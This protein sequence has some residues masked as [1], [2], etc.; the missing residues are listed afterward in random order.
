MKNLIVD[1]P[2]P[3]RLSGRNLAIS[4]VIYNLL[5]EREELFSFAVYGDWG[6][7]KT[8]V[9]K[10]VYNRLKTTIEKN[11]TL[12]N[13]YSI[14][15]WFEAW[16]FQNEKFIFPAMLRTIGSEIAINAKSAEAITLCKRLMKNSMAV[17]KA[18]ISSVK[19]SA[20]YN[21]PDTG[22]GGGLE[23]SGNDFLERF[24]SEMEKSTESSL[25]KL[26]QIGQSPYFEAY[27][28]LKS[29]VNEIKIKGKK[30][31]IVIFIDDLDRCLPDVAF[32][33]IEQIKI[34][35][36]IN[37]YII[38]FALNKHEID[39]VVQNYFRSRMKESDNIEKLTSEYLDK[40][41]NFGIYLDKVPKTIE[42]N[43]KKDFLEADFKS[44]DDIIK[45][46]HENIDL[47]DNVHRKAF[48][49]FNECLIE[50]KIYDE[51]NPPKK[52]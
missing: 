30:I 52:K 16:R 31:R 42:K 45:K 48:K 37:G 10:S 4:D 44:E 20:A 7:G 3:E 51:I 28:I 8:T 43:S 21:N 5:K 12:N 19:V 11:E 17:M 49:I 33:I 24:D 6:S 18:A 39:N 50:K 34:W 26:L 35:L 25:T 2:K 27:E 38:C 40:I 1:R 15:V 14:P 47:E 46:V 9:C 13:A 36:D 41:I 32:E 22:I 23:L 29:L